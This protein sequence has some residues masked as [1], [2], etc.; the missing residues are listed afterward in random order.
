MLYVLILLKLVAIPFIPTF[1]YVVGNLKG[2]RVAGELVE[3][4]DT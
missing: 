4:L 3:T 2:F 1:A